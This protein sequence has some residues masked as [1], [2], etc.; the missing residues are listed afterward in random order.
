[1][2]VWICDGCGFRVASRPIAGSELDYSNHG[3]RSIPTG[4]DDLQDF[5]AG[6]SE[7]VM[8]AAEQCGGLKKTV[9]EVH[10]PLEADDESILAQ[11]AMNLDAIKSALL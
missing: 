10:R 5:C 9:E 8:A 4:V 7:K 3:F 1:M 6:C 2:I 11:N